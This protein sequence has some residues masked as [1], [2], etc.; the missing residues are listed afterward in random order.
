MCAK[1]KFSQFSSGFIKNKSRCKVPSL[2]RLQQFYNFTR[3]LKN[4]PPE[5]RTR[6]MRTEI[7]C[8]IRY[9]KGAQQ[10]NYSTLLQKL[11]QTNTTP[12]IINLTRRTNDED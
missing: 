5:T 3:L 6:I 7:S 11:K 2:R 10:F 4:A 8:A 1:N 12:V 9:T